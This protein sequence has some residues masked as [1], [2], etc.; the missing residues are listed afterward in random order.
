MLAFGDMAWVPFA[1]SLQAYYLVNPANAIGDDKLIAFCI[2]GFAGYYVFRSSN[3]QKDAFRTDPNSP[4]VKHLK[5][6]KTNH[7]NGRE[8][9]ISGWWGTARKINYTGDLAEKQGAKTSKNIYPNSGIIVGKAKNILN[10]YKILNMKET[11]D[12][13]AL[14]TELMLKRPD[15][16]IMDYEQK[17]IGNNAW[18]EG[19]DGCVFDWDAEK[20]KFKH[21][22]FETF[23]AF[24]H[25]Q[26]KFYECY[27]KLARHFGFKGNMRRKLVEA[28]AGNNYDTTSKPSS[29]ASPKQY[30]ALLIAASLALSTF[31]NL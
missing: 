5:T 22:T 10:S 29:S 4:S 24:L 16:V 18:T 21:P 12:D 11:E 23:P 3:G 27:G 25:F 6:L 26:G 30:S 19:M 14:F 9:L 1:Y 7:P 2:L 13:Q 8:L 20:E 28:P 31:F 15:L 17:L